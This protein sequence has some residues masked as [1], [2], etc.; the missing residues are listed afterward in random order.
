MTDVLERI[1]QAPS[2]LARSIQ[3]GK[4]AG[5]RPDPHRAVWALLATLS[6]AAGVIHLVMVPS[7]WG[8]SVAEGIGF[9]LAGW[10]QLA[11][12]WLVFTRRSHTVLRIAAVANFA[13]VGA[14]AYSR[15]FGLPF[16]AHAGHAETVGFVDA[17]T[18]AFEAVF[19]AGALLLLLRPGFGRSWSRATL[20]FS[21]VV[22]IAVVVLATAAIASPGARDHAAGSHGDHG[23]AGHHDA[24][25]DAG[26]GH[27]DAA[28]VDDR[29]LSLLSNGHHHEIG[30]EQPLDPST[31]AEL[32]RQIAVTQQVGEMY[33]T[34]AA[35]EAAGYRRAGPYSPGLGLHLVRPS[36][37]GLN[38]DGVMD[39]EDLLS[40]M[41][42]I[43]AG[44]HPEAPIAGFMYY[45]TSV[46]EPEGFAGPNDIWHYHTNTCVRFNADG[47]IDAPFGADTGDVP[48][49]LCEQAGG[50]MLEQTQWM[51]HVW[52]LPGWESQQGL[53]GEVNPAL[54]CSDGTYYRLPIKEW[55]D[56]PINV[57]RSEA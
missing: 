16:G 47:T 31:R 48:V 6:A 7:H 26:H 12:A 20:G 35:A 28:S 56:H 17:T 46:D 23:A 18:V 43:Y 27:A 15:A 2:G 38:G 49:S 32:T 30:L 9:A 3:T 11:L 53:F 37:P 45:S 14:W 55:V 1:E 51:V 24:A 13:F 5:G 40:P 25:D 22:A 33:P 50:T 54:A 44:T 21:A 36:G 10:F 41:S 34:I 42:I 8:E 19:V 4:P 29:G 39:D 52:S 57:C